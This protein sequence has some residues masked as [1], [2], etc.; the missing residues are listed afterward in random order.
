[1]IYGTGGKTKWHRK[2]AGLPKTHYY[3]AACVA[4]VPQKDDILSVFAIHAVG[5]GHHQ[6]L[7]MYQTK[8]VV[9]S[10]KNKRNVPGWKHPYTRIEHTNGFQKLDTVA[11]Q[12]K[13]GRVVGCLNTFDKTPD[14][15]SQKLVLCQRSVEG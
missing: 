10:G 7:G 3:D 1:M 6:D 8:K 9:G 2:R 14:G 4:C 12:T 11:M 15:R 5:Y 13:K